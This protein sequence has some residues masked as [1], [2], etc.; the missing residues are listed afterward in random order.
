MTEY[1]IGEDNV[2]YPTVRYSVKVHIGVRD[3]GDPNRSRLKTAYGE[4]LTAAVF[5]EAKFRSET[6]TREEPAIISVSQWLVGRVQPR[7]DG[8]AFDSSAPQHM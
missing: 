4:R 8:V 5:A 6:G 7:D 2:A 1:E 3:E